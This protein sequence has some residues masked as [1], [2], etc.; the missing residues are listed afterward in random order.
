MI[1]GV[2][3]ENAN[4]GPSLHGSQSTNGM[5]VLDSCS[6]AHV[7]AHCREVNQVVDDEPM[8]YDYSLASHVFQSVRLCHTYFNL[9]DSPPALNF[10]SACNLRTTQTPGEVV[11]LYWSDV[12]GGEGQRFAYVQSR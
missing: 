12:L 10:I 5:F 3:N 11:G 4:K 9:K 6:Q 8:Q 7:D 1:V 2:N